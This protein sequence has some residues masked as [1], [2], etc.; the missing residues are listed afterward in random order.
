MSPS[1]RHTI[2]STMVARM[3]LLERI[4][5]GKTGSTWTVLNSDQNGLTISSIL[6]SNSSEISRLGR[7]RSSILQKL[8]GKGGEFEGW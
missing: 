6:A 8:M 7:G 2:S 5:L 3:V 4:G 1:N